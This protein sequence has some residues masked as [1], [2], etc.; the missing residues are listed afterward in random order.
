MKPM[1][2]PALRQVLHTLYR[3]LPWRRMA[4]LAKPADFA[5]LFILAS[6]G[7]A[8][9]SSGQRSV[10]KALLLCTTLVIL[11]PLARLIHKTA[12]KIWANQDHAP[13]KIIRRIPARLLLAGIMLSIVS[14]I[15]LFAIDPLALYVGLA[16]SGLAILFLY[17]RRRIFPGEMLLAT[18][19]ASIMLLGVI[20]GTGVPGKTVSLAWLT[21]ILWLSSAFTQQ[22]ATRL[23]AHIRLGL[24]SITMLAGRA[25]RWL[26]AV[27][28]GLTLLGYLL[29][30]L[31]VKSTISM[32]LAGLTGLL[33]VL[34][35]QFLMR[36]NTEAAYHKA[37]LTNLWFGFIL[38]TGLFI[39]TI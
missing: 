1:F 7:Y 17:L 14:G 38:C 37:W 2:H 4:S 11:A 5:L 33:F 34:Y 32:M 27:L 36:W 30:A 3:A 10:G 9:G 8:L 12:L 15:L 39:A 35:Q 18:A 16:G 21:S 20:A 26:I 24:R 23:Q 28:Q 6:W 29:L 25:D 13:W 22:A 31:Q 19:L